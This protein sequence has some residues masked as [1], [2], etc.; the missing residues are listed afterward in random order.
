MDEAVSALESHPERLLGS[1]RE[2]MLDL[3]GQQRFEEAAE[4]RRR[5]A[6]L[7]GALRRHRQVESLRSAGRIAVEAAGQGVTTLDRGRLV[8]EHETKA[9]SAPQRKHGLAVA[10]KE[11]IDELWCVASWLESEAHTLR[12][13]H[14]DHPLSSPYPCLDDF[15]ARKGV[16]LQ[17]LSLIHI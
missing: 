17:N 16:V 7:S 6:A 13:V 15:R 3:A 12:L 14:C 2:R 4:V 1:L 11:E 10:S 9:F 5:A 8:E